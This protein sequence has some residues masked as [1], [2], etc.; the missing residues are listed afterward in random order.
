MDYT[1]YLLYTSEQEKVFRDK[2]TSHLHLL[3]KYEKWFYSFPLY[4]W[5]TIQVHSNTAQFTLGMLC[6]LKISKR[7][8]FCFKFPAQLD[9]EALIMRFARDR[10]EFEDYWHKYLPKPLNKE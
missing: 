3:D 8:N 10:N 2:Y 6:L 5:H 1:H 9:N 4:E 7:A